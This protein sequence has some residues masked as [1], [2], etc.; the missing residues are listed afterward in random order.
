MTDAVLLQQLGSCG[1]ITLNRPE[2]LNALTLDM[3]RALDP[4]LRA[5]AQDPSITHVVIEGAGEKGFCAGGDIRALHDWGRAGAAEATGFYREEYVVNHLIKHF[6]KPYIALMDGVT[7]GG[8]V[9]VSVHGMFRIV[10]D[11]TVFAMPETGIGL[12]PDV[13]GTYF[14]PRLPGELGTYLALTGNRFKAADCLYA[15]VGTHYVALESFEGLR[16]A[17]LACDHPEAV[18]AALE[19]ASAHCAASAPIKARQ[20]Q[21]DT[22]FAGDRVTDIIARLVADEDPWAQDLAKLIEAKSPTSCAVA[23]HQMRAGA[24]A[25]FDA[26]MKM[27]MR[28]VS[29]I[30]AQHDFYEGVRAVII[31]KDQSPK[32]S[33]AMHGDISDHDIDVIFSSL[34]DNELVFG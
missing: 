34:G 16:D 19:D 29:R 2:A 27:E 3:V 8:G 7:M 23:L 10:T 28:A 12:L 11:R 21:I 32:W 14:L 24:Q 33:P 18:L 5:W 4:Q 20:E 13:G 30:M 6:P 22:L 25:S 9:G 17:L 26:C 15:G 31:D 1:L